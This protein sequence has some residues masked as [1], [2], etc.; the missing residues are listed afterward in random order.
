MRLLSF[1]NQDDWP[2]DAK[3]IKQTWGKAQFEQIN[4]GRIHEIYRMKVK[5]YAST[6]QKRNI[7]KTYRGL[8]CFFLQMILPRPTFAQLFEP[9]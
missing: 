2:C 7:N 4:I 6:R 3:V 1:D 5:K 8:P 9:K